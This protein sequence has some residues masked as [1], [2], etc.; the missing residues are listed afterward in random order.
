L[1]DRDD[2]KYIRILETNGGFGTVPLWLDYAKSHKFQVVSST[3]I[4]D[5]PYC[6]NVDF[7]TVGQ[8]VHYSNLITLNRCLICDLIF[9]DTLLNA[10][11]ISEHFERSYKD[12]TYF[13]LQRREIFHHIV[14]LC[15]DMVPYGGDILDIGGAKGHLLDQIAKKRPDANC[16]LN[17]MSESACS[18][19][20]QKYGLE[21]FCS[22]SSDLARINRKFDLILAIDVIYYEPELAKLFSA[23]SSIAK[24]GSRLI[25]RIPNHHLLIRATSI[26]EKRLKSEQSRALQH[27]VRW[28]NP[29][30][31][32]VFSRDFLTRSLQEVGF[33]RVSFN[34]SPL[35]IRQ[36]YPSFLTKTAFALS[37]GFNCLSR[38][39]VV[40]TPSQFVIATK[41][42]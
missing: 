34:A 37:E 15:D 26:L 2:E 21:T 32:Y 27:K 38:G 17:D 41:T 36:G 33:F 19:A 8:Y 28:F 11:T 25:I 42:Q 24:H 31:L 9:S 23:I 10:E 20:E 3:R 1:S 30:H 39:K 6:S 18:Y 40:F 4:E 5:C 22:P 13:S 12:E 35:L 7:E 14:Q 29:E 16:V